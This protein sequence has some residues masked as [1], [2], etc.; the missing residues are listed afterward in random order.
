[1]DED[2]WFPQMLASRKTTAEYTKLAK[3]SASSA[4]SVA[5]NSFVL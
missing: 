5:E 2:S 4:L 1:M 3:I